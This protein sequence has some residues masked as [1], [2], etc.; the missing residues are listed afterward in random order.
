M[1]KKNKGSSAV[2]PG[3]G[4]IFSQEIHFQGEKTTKAQRLFLVKALAKQ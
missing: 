4:S 1:S 3:K 2:K